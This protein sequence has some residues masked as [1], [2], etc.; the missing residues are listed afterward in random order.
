MNV[1][2]SLVLM[3]LVLLIFCALTSTVLAVDITDWFLEESYDR[4]VVNP[5]W[6][7]IDIVEGDND[8]ALLGHDKPFFL[9]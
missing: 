7:A 8:N 9:W 4:C 2:Q 3:G 1:K 5:F 6:V